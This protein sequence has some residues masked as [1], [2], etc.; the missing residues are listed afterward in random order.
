[1]SGQFFHTTL[2]YYRLNKYDTS[3]VLRILKKFKNVES[4]FLIS[5]SCGSGRR[6]RFKKE[7]ITFF[8]F[9]PLLPGVFFFQAF[10]TP[11]SYHAR[12]W[13]TPGGPRYSAPT[14]PRHPVRRRSTTNSSSSTTTTT[15]G[16]ERKTSLSSS[17]LSSF[18][19]N[20]INIF[21]RDWSIPAP[22]PPPPPRSSEAAPEI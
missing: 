8:V 5:S 15:S 9:F 4:V 22:P 20:N 13:R 1:M 16:S 11:D 7:F 21:S 12:P 18:H 3:R 14:L 19:Q 2:H 10:L 6:K 17:S